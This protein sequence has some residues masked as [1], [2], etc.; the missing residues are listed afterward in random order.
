MN[1]KNVVPI[2]TVPNPRL[3]EKMNL[4]IEVN[5]QLNFATSALTDT[6][7]AKR[8]P[9]GVGLAAPQIDLDLQIFAT[10]LSPAA[11]GTGSS[12][13]NNIDIYINPT[14]SKHSAKLS[15]GETNEDPVL[16]G[17]LS[18]PKL[19]GAVPR[20]EWIELEFSKVE[21]NKLIKTKQ[22]FTDFAARVVQHELDHLH[23]ILFTD[24][25]LEYDLPVYQE[26]NTGKLV[27]IDI[28]ILEIF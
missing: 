16:E 6:L 3:R 8:N 20:W 7:K 10:Q 5:E 19:Y 23:G 24:Y 27:P 22:R 26:T 21:K 17:C 15:L 28:S 14:I 4:V 13:K 9:T 18:I 12:E 11:L 2:I 1:N 25:S